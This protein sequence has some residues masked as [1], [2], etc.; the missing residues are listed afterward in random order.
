MNQIVGNLPMQQEIIASREQI[1]YPLP[2]DEFLAPWDPFSWRYVICFPM[3][4]KIHSENFP[5][6]EIKLHGQT[7]TKAT[8][9]QKEATDPPTRKKPGLRG[10]EGHLLP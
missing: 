1:T 2:V 3:E 4:D 5:E 8:P 9:H 7:P 6:L 10:Y